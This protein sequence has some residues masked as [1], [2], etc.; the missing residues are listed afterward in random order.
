MR[1]VESVLISHQENTLKSANTELVSFLSLFAENAPVLY[2]VQGSTEMYLHQLV[3][4]AKPQTAT[5]SQ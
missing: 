4:Y 5:I 3:R 2:N 1:K